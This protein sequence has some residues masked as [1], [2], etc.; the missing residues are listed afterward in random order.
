MAARLGTRTDQ[1]CSGLSLLRRSLDATLRSLEAHATVR[2]TRAVEDLD[3]ERIRRLVFNGDLDELSSREARYVV[4]SFLQFPAE[5]LAELLEWRPVLRRAFVRQALLRWESSLTRSDW[6]DYVEVL[7]RFAPSESP[8]EAPLSLREIAGQDGARKAAEAVEAET[9]GEVHRTVVEDWRL[10]P[11]WTLTPHVLLE[12][13]RRSLGTRHALSGPVRE[14]FDSEGDVLRALLLPPPAPTVASGRSTSPSSP[15]RRAVTHGSLLVQIRAVATLLE[16][17]FSQRMSLDEATFAALE[18]ALLRSTFGDPRTVTISDAWKQV[19]TLSTQPYDA[20]LQ[21]LVRED[22]ALFFRHLMR[23]EDRE[24]FWLRYLGSIRRTLC[25]LDR[26]A[27]SALD[28]KLTGAPEA[29]RAA[30]ARV[31]R[32]RSKNL[33]GTCAFCLFFDDF[34]MVEFSVVGNAG[35]LY[36]RQDFERQFFSRIQGGEFE[37]PAS[38]KDKRVAKF[39]LVHQRRWQHEMELEL[40]RYGIKS[41]QRG[42]RYAP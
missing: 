14:L 20:F 22:L 42:A 7:G 38:L 15:P 11:S 17:R 16:A 25:V 9:L 37:S 8:I 4:L 35:Y 26:D 1:V 32:T 34:V 40:R 28:H 12:W 33:D 3:A 29:T 23:E 39:R 5:R 30:L 24:R 27:Y 31:V 36:D 41:D 18:P 19:R 10:Q 21:G 6:E 13:M 2:Q